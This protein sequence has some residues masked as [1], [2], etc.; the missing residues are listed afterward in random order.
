MQH[1]HGTHDISL[2]VLSF[3][4]AFMAS[5]TALDT[6]RRVHFSTGWQRKLWLLSGSFAMG[7]G[8][9][10]MHFIAM[11]AFELPVPIY[12]DLVLVFVSIIVAIAA[13]MCGLYFSCK[14]NMN[15]AKLVVGGTIMGIGISGMHYIG[16]AA[17]EGIH[18]TYQPVY[19][20]VSICIAIGASIIALMLTFRFRESQQGIGNKAKIVSGMVMAIAI[21]GMHYTG[22]FGARFIPDHQIAEIDKTSLDM[23][24]V[25]TAVTISTIV[26]LGIVLVISFVLDRRLDE[27]ITFKDAI[28][29]SVLDCLIIINNKGNIIEC[30]PAVTTTFGHAR[31][32]LIGQHMEQKLLGRLAEN[33]VETEKIQYNQRVEMT[34]IRCNGET[35]PVELTVTKI[36]KEGLPLFTVY[37]RDITQLKQS[38]ETIWKM[39]YRDSLTG[40]PNRRFFSEHLNVSLIEA[41]VHETKLAV[42]FLD[43]DHFKLINDSMGHAFG[44]ILLKSVAERLRKCVEAPD[45]VA[46][47]GG[48]EFTLILQD[49]NDQL[50][51]TVVENII[52]ALN[53]PFDLGEQEVF[54]STSIGI[55]MYPADGEDQEVLVKNADTAMYEA[56][57]QGR[58]GYSFFK[59]GHEMK[60]LK[61]HQLGN[62]LRM[63]LE[64]DELILHYQPRLHMGS[65]QIIGVEALVRWIHP[66]KGFIPPDEFIPQAEELGLIVPIGEWVL[67][68]AVAQC[69]KWQEQGLSLQMS[70]NLS[71]VQFQK[72]DIVKVV[73]ETLQREELAP[74]LLNLEITES[75]MMNAEYSIRVLQELKTLGVQLS[76]DDFGTGYNSLSSLKKMPLDYLKIDRS[77]MHNIPDDPENTAIVKAIISI[78]QSLN[79]N[80]I[81]EGIEEEQ[82]LA[83]LQQLHCHEIQGYLV[84][85]PV[86]A[87][88]LERFLADYMSLQ[89]LQLLDG[90]SAS[91]TIKSSSP[92]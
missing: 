79:L 42:I 2:V 43:L 14:T 73:S 74:G 91:E 9:W 64:R 23:D 25:V 40:L 44:D 37:M 38:E 39:A 20:V 19:F 57:E 72:A 30:N 55:S 45:I 60:M 77:F 41:E 63:A 90:K 28:L 15:I 75:M 3:A 53:E 85:R 67:R 52:Y 47:N 31:E 61:K 50:A 21:A 12:Y 24:A 62:E 5:L 48:D 84:C 8:I 82:Q 13:S 70:V 49:T 10:A 35:F 7:I 34:G 11:I 83:F 66:E 87:Q 68:T 16:M 76:V 89:V 27:E 71:A 81:A 59:A 86:P 58:N 36:K 1:M 54:I 33:N 18:I 17:M 92:L 69:K 29:E 88:E 65:G 32:E 4:I 56:K 46:R 78:A 6:A 51:E 22:M 26:I 80:V